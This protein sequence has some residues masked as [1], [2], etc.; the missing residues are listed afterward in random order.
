MERVLESELLDELPTSDPEALRSRRDLQRLNF[1]MNHAA[2]A[3]RALR[4]AVPGPASCVVEL[5]AGDGTFLLRVAQRMESWRKVR[6]ILVDRQP[7]VSGETIKG[8]AQIGWEAVTVKADVF[9]WLAN[10]EKEAVD[11]IFANLFLHHFSEEQLRNLFSRAAVCARGLVA[12]EPR[13]AMLPLLMTHLLWFIGCSRVTRHDAPVSVRA[14]FR[15]G[16][17]SQHWPED[18]R[19]RLREEKV[20]LFSH[21]FMAVRQHGGA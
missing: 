16:E 14:G 3:V 15:N 10:S 18:E 8:F 17:V 1:W 20:G 4:S 12:L 19:W 2:M 11:A 13:R 21:L 7:S 5:G 6:A 9:E